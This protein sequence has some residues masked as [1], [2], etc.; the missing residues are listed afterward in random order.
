MFPASTD[1]RTLAEDTISVSVMHNYPCPD[2]ICDKCELRRSQGCRY[3]DKCREHA[4][5][6]TAIAQHAQSAM[7]E[8]TF[9]YFAN[10]AGW[11][12]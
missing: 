2:P 5:P 7:T 11:K 6:A 3:C 1:L 10:L 9:T 8:G 12:L 4:H